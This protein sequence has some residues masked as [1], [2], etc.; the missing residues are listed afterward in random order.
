[1]KHGK[2]GRVKH[3]NSWRSFV[4]DVKQF[5]ALVRLMLVCLGMVAAVILLVALAHVATADL[6]SILFLLLLALAIAASSTRAVELPSSKVSIIISVTDIFIFLA[7]VTLGPYHAVLLAALEGLLVGRR[8][9]VKLFAHFFNIS[10]IVTSIYLAGKIYS[11]MGVAAIKLSASDRL[12]VFALP[13]IALALSHYLI[14]NVTVALLLKLR[15]NQK[16]KDTLVSRLPWE[17]AAY[18]ASAT[19]AGAINYVFQQ[20]GPITA[21]TALLMLLPVPLIVYY[22]FK[23]YREKLDEQQRYFQQINELNE[24]IME[25]LAMAIDAKDEVTHKHIQRVRFFACRMGQI[26]G[27]S[28]SEIE[29]LKAGALLHD[30]GKIGVPSHILNKPGKLTEH[31]FEQM[32]MHTI[33]GADMLSSINF[34][35]PV[36]PIVRHHHERWDGHGYPDGLKG[37]EIPITARILTLVDSYDA[38]RSDRPYK[39]AMS[40]QEAISFIKQNAG[41]MYDPQLVEVFLSVLDQLEAEAANHS[42]ESEIRE[43]QTIVTSRATSLAFKTARP[44]AGFAAPPKANRA[45]RALNSIAEVHQRVTALYEMSRTLASSLSL[46]DTMAILSNRLS[47]LIPFTTCAISLLNPSHS[48]Y[49]FVHAVGRNAERFMK[50]RLPIGTGITGWVIQNQRPIYNTNPVLD[51]GFLSPDESNEYKGVIVFPLVKNGQPIGAIS[52]YSTEVANYTVEFIQ[53]IESISQPVADAIYNALA[54]EQAQRAAMTDAA[55]GLPNLRAFS[56]QFERERA[57]SRRL[58]TPLSIILIRVNN[59]TEVAA[60]AGTTSEL[61]MKSL[62]KLITQQTRESDLTAR[63]CAESFLLLLPDSGVNQAAQLRNR[64]QSAIIE[65]N[66]Q[67]SDSVALGSATSPDNGETLDDLIEAAHINCLTS[68]KSILEA[69]T[70]DLDGQS[71]AKYH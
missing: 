21:M 20:A 39:K 27:L 15:H 24:S 65:W 52:L 61:F 58:G 64:L 70:T 57:R 22:A 54:F 51:L 29:A 4:E 3:M 11:A 34:P 67:A 68:R 59:L 40:R 32:K 53:L 48:E 55:T 44:A 31:E 56:N 9:K 5:S 7:V 26:V 71:V 45:A 62:G 36:V 50:R 2:L 28:E 38:L 16:V 17:P 6:S 18:L 25:M 12:V 63:Y 13:I 19:A 49:E 46:E 42:I 69:V 37:E 47:K 8:L 14:N 30:V 1:M 60:K 33:I 10:N 23:A 66:Y 35:Y 41:K 43:K